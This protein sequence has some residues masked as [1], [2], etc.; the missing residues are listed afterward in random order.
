LFPVQKEW[1]LREIDTLY[2]DICRTETVVISGG[3]WVRGEGGE[4]LGGGGRGE[5]EKKLG[6]YVDIWAVGTG[7]IIKILPMS[8]HFSKFMTVSQIQTN[9]QLISE[10]LNKSPLRPPNPRIEKTDHEHP[11]HVRTQS[12]FVS[13]T[14]QPSSYS[15]LGAQRKEF[16]TKSPVVSS[17]VLSS[18]R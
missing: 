18:Y 11:T 13:P 6:D 12:S 8:M 17:Q 2:A 7:N 1:L 10:Q 15:P 16:R 4:G 14:A 3:F 9:T 5:K